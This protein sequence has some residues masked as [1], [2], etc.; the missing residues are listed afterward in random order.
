MNKISIDN[1]YIGEA[2]PCFII[3]ELSANH[4]QDFA[5]AKEII[6]AAKQAGADAVKFQTYLPSTMTIDSHQE[7]FQVPSNSIWAGKTLFELYGEAYTPWEWHAELFNIAHEEGLICFST[8][9]DK[10]SIDLLEDLN[11]PVYKVASF[12]VV[13]LPLLKEIGKT[14]KPVIM[15]TG[16]ATLSEIAEAIKTL[17]ESGAGPLILLKCTSAYPASPESMNLK[18]IPH[19]R[20]TFNTIVGLSDHT[21]GSAV[22]VAAVALGA[23]VIEK[24]FTLARSDGGPDSS[25]S[26]EPDEFAKMVTDI[27]V[28]E[29]ALGKISY[30]R[31]AEEQKNVCF[32]RSL[33]VV[34]DMKK[35]EAFSL[36]NLQSI[37]PGNGLA[38]RY[39]DIVLGKKVVKDIKRGTPVSWDLMAAE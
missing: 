14:G 21:L 33:F 17:R 25:F 38:P 22:P 29:K 24:H 3:A 32:R 2:E 7:W 12:E 15:S 28:I 18:S 10:T 4:N 34:Q 31:T 19:L 8:P 30:E 1:R 20:D 39:M 36:S 23:S 16:M 11:V 26:L 5:R 13:D 6:K 9:F 37:R 27:R 35:G